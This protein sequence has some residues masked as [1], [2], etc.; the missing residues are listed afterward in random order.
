MSKLLDDKQVCINCGA[1]IQETFNS[2]YPWP[3]CSKECIEEN[4]EK[5]NKEYDE[6][7]Y[8]RYGV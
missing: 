2:R 1:V 6:Y 4:E 8:E 7:L 5:M 3:V